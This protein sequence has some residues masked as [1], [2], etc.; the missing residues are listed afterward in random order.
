MHHRIRGCASIALLLAFAA[1]S[2]SGGPAEPSEPPDEPSPQVEPDR[3]EDLR[4]ESVT[5]SSVT[6]GFVEVGDGTESPADYDIRFGTPTITFESAPSVESGTCA[7]PVMGSEIGAELTCSVQGL[8]AGTRY[9]FR[10]AAF[11]GDLEEDPTFGDPSNIAADTLAPDASQLSFEVRDLSPPRSSSSAS[12][13]INSRGEVVGS[14]LT[15][16][17]SSVAF[18]WT[19]AAGEA[20]SLGTLPEADHSVADD[21]NRHGQVVGSSGG[22]AFIWSEQEG[23]REIGTPG[24]AS[25]F[26]SAIND[27]GVV[28]GHGET[29]EGATVAFLWT[30][31]EG[32][33]SLGTLPDA[34]S[35]RAL[36]V[37]LRGEVVG[38]SGERAFLWTDED[39]MR[40]LGTL[41]GTTS[42][43]AAINEAGTIV[44]TSENGSGSAEAFL[45]TEEEG[46]AGL[47]TLGGDE[48][49]AAGI[50]RWGDVVGTSDT[51]EQAEQDHERIVG[52]LWSGGEGM[53]EL[54]TLY[55]PFG[56]GEAHAV[57]GSL[58]IAG[59]SIDEAIEIQAT[60]W[61]PSEGEGS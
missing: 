8:S 29:E 30:E 43:A 44:G 21:I 49:S 22:R 2:D 33:V 7:T 40:D 35:S 61:T 15:P 10:V 31:A 45:W 58:E 55:P 19:E 51:G 14:M 46:M 32:M 56:R 25:S 17:G 16:E 36:D 27:E 6:L 20:R 57:N 52:F 39:G 23:M 4:V 5:D 60:R 9:E 24:G 54:E 11:R 13:G 3:V 47:G 48:S 34:P 50:N 53:R 26:A 37:N 12:V 41:G 18:L 59:Q 42:E 28:V 1:C 38:S